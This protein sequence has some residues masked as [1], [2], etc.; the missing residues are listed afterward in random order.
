[1]NGNCAVC[2]SEMTFPAPPQA[3][4][5]ARAPLRLM[6]AGGGSALAS[7]H[8]PPAPPVPGRALPCGHAFHEA[9]IKQWLV[10]CHRCAPS[11]CCRLPSLHSSASVHVLAP[12]QLAGAGRLHAQPP[13]L[14]PVPGRALPRGHAFHKACI[15]QWL[16]QCHGCAPPAAASS[17]SVAARFHKF[18]PL[19]VCWG[20]LPPCPAA[21]TL[22]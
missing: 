10:Q 12:W 1:M 17:P 18:W 3:P 11:C 9:C 20:R 19:A 21:A 8:P 14:L 15:K 7:L 5:L 4:P 2:W 22:P 13:P 16:V 6:G